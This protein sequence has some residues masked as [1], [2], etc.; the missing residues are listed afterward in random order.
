[1]HVV[2][3]PGRSTRVACIVAIR[4]RK[5]EKK[6][7]SF[8]ASPCPGPTATH[9]GRGTQG[10]RAWLAP[11]S[12]AQQPEE[13]RVSACPQKA[14][15]RSYSTRY[16]HLPSPPLWVCSSTPSLI[17]RAGGDLAWRPE[18]DASSG[19]PGWASMWAGEEGSHLCL[20][21]GR[22]CVARVC[23]LVVELSQ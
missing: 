21:G 20:C 16:S 12:E 13:L 8:G 14:N 2:P 9:P 5:R 17:D 15:F 1:M 22:S 4:C 3:S 6:N 10:Q 11:V 18:V 7:N 23:C 19:G